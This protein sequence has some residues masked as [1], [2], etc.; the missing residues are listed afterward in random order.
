MDDRDL[1]TRQK[2]LQNLRLRN[3]KLVLK[4]PTVRSV[5]AVHSLVSPEVGLYGVTNRQIWT[6]DVKSDHWITVMK[7]SLTSPNSQQE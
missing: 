5:K 2:L 6:T 3:R 4:I 7:K 1:E